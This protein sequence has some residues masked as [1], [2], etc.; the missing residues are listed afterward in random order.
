MILILASEEGNDSMPGLTLIDQSEDGTVLANP[1][2][3]WVFH[4]FPDALVRSEKIDIALPL[5]WELLIGT[6][7]GQTVPKLLNV[8]FVIPVNRFLVNWKNSSI[9]LKLPNGL[10]NYSMY[11]NLFG[12][13]IHFQI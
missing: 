2:I 5:F 8:I 9:V 12:R 4:P 10:V 1:E 11:I 13:S 7:D 3:F 6:A